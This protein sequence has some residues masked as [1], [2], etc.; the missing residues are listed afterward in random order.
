MA[1]SQTGQPSSDA[2]SVCFGP[3][4]GTDAAVNEIVLTRE[5][6]EALRL[7]DRDGVRLRVAAA[8][9]GIPTP[10]FHKIIAG[11]RR[12]VADAITRGKT[13]GLEK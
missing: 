6:W 10:S 3:I 12:K 9:L 8:M 5:E 2:P 13:L 4:D 1:E 7:N 11:A